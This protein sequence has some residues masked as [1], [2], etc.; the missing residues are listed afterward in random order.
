VG[1]KVTQ[2]NDDG[3]FSLRQCSGSTGY[4]WCVDKDGNEV[5]DSSRGPG[6]AKDM[7]CAATP[8]AVSPCKTRAT[9]ERAACAGKMGCSV[10]M[11]SDDGSFTPKQCS[12]S[13]GY[14]WC[15]DK[16]GKEVDGTR[17]PP[18]KGG[19]LN[20]VAA[21]ALSPCKTR[22]ASDTT[23]CAGKMGCTVTQCNDDG[24]FVGKQCSG[25]TGFC[26]CVN[27]DGNEIDGSRLGPGKDP[28]CANTT[29]MAMSQPSVCACPMIACA[30][31]WK[32]QIKAGTENNC[33][34][35]TYECIAPV[36]KPS[37]PKGKK[38]KKGKNPK[39]KAK[40]A[41]GDMMAP[42]GATAAGGTP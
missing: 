12:G 16:D 36:V 14:C 31:G 41:G 1:C 11:C 5:A 20:C 28:N 9:T 34:H 3:S 8:P 25:S 26:W 18:G 6:K 7:N 38:G 32:A 23:T 19:D 30:P 35:G 4:C 37:K 24:S 40:A 27:S 39:A 22:A 29:P 17:Q 15:V 33:C 42:G 2:C 21:P 10:I 13:T